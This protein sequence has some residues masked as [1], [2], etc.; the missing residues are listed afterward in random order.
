MLTV[1]ASLKSEIWEARR[2]KRNAFLQDATGD[3]VWQESRASKPIH[4]RILG[5]ITGEVGLIGQA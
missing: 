4:N 1:G 2:E 5:T 3:K